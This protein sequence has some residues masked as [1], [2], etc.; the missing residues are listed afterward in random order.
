MLWLRTEWKGAMRGM[1]SVG[2]CVATFMGV[3]AGRLRA[4]VLEHPSAADLQGPFFVQPFSFVTVDSVTDG[5]GQTS[6]YFSALPL[7][8][9]PSFQV[10]YGLGNFLVFNSLGDP[11]TNF[12][13]TGVSVTTGGNTFSPPFGLF[14]FAG[15]SSVTYTDALNPLN[16][17]TLFATDYTIAFEAM[18]D[19]S[20]TSTFT[21]DVTGTGLDVGS[22]V[23]FDHFEATVP[24]PVYTWLLGTALLLFSRASRRWK[25]S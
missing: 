21:L 16:S 15:N 25:R 17:I 5:V 8:S 14:N 4:G 12:N 1:L 22:T 24:E 13:V 6:G 2:L 7:G 23:V 3:T 20:L 10:V 11:V 9:Y 19:A 18:N